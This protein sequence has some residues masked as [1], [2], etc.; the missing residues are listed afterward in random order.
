MF[1]CTHKDTGV[2]I[3]VEKTKDIIIYEAITVNNHIRSENMTI[4]VNHEMKSSARASGVQ[5]PKKI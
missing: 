2:A 3:S 1:L 5:K 4:K